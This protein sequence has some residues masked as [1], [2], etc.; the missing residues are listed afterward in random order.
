MPAKGRR[1]EER[2]VRLLEGGD[3]LEARVRRTDTGRMVVD[4]ACSLCQGWIQRQVSRRGPPFLS[5][6]PLHM[7]IDWLRVLGGGFLIEVVLMVV[8]IGGFAAAGVDL[9]AGVSNVS[10]VVIG[11]GCFVVAFVV[12]AWLT[13]GIE[14]QRAWNGLLMGV[15]A[16]L[17]YLGLV[18]GSGQM[19]AALAAYGPATFVIVNGVRMAGALLG[20]I[21]SERRSGA[22]AQPAHASARTR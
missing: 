3:G 2:L 15:V 6:L 14:H 18:A 17:L 5:T 9:A 7:P 20:G 22:P 4:G 1:G 16:T 11:V 10:A 19:A 13:R 8:L 12:A 21:V